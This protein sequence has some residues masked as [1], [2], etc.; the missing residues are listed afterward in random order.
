MKKDCTTN[1]QIKSIISKVKQKPTCIFSLQKIRIS[2]NTFEKMP[3][4]LLNTK[5]V[6][7]LKERI[8]RFKTVIE[9]L[10]NPQ[11]GSF[12]NIPP[13]KMVYNEKTKKYKEWRCPF[14]QKLDCELQET[15]NCRVQFWKFAFIL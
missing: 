10:C 9:L 14:D 7:P 13:P 3:F 8:S 6:K 11:T 2:G 15:V 1:L 12:K 4:D 5:P